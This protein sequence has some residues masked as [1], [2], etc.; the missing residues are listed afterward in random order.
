MQINDPIYNVAAEYG[1]DGQVKWWSDLRRH[2][3]VECTARIGKRTF[4]FWLGKI[5]EWEFVKET[6]P[7]AKPRV[8]RKNH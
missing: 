6:T 3:P 7:G 2:S 8:Y 5:D 4:R 1:L